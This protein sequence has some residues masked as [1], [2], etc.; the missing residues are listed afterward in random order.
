MSYVL[1]VYRVKHHIGLSGLAGWYFWPRFHAFFFFSRELLS[2]MS[3]RRLLIRSVKSNKIGKC[4]YWWLFFFWQFL[5]FAFISVSFIV[6]VLFYV[7]TSVTSY[8]RLFVLLD[9]PSFLEQIISQFTVWYSLV[10]VIIF[11]KYTGSWTVKCYHVRE[12]YLAGLMICLI[13]TQV[14]TWLIFTLKP[15]EITHVFHCFK[16]M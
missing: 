16:I 4:F 2:I 5:M 6:K 15:R 1:P 13:S 9:R 12:I 14:G 11:E 10:S 7:V 3:F 8:I